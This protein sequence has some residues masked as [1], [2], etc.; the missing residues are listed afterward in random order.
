M[1]DGDAWRCAADDKICY[2]MERRYMMRVNL[3]DAT[4][5]L[6][7]TVFGAQVIL[8]TDR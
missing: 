8:I 3:M 2:S 7:V 5:E 6:A 4:G 1:P